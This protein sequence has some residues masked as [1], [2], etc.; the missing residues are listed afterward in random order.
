MPVASFNL[1]NLGLGLTR[2]PLRTYVLT[3][4]L[5]MVPGAV[6]YSYVGFAGRRALMG[7]ENWMQAL[8]AALAIMAALGLLPFL[9][10]RLHFMRRARQAGE[11]RL[12]SRDPEAPA[13]SWREEPQGRA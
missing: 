6:G 8:T 3:T 12:Q 2:I 5:C 13:G 4:M 9:V 7:E 10:R 1:I 11:G